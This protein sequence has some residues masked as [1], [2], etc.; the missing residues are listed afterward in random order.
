MAHRLVGGLVLQSTPVNRLVPAVLATA[1]WY[2]VL[3]EGPLQ[4]SYIVVSL[5]PTPV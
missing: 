1:E 5:L 3:S 2:S 4:L